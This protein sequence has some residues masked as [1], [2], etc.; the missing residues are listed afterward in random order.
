MQKKSATIVVAVFTI[1]AVDFA[2]NVG[3]LVLI[4]IPTPDIVSL[5]ILDANP[6]FLQFKHVVGVLLSILY[7]S[8]SNSW[9]LHG[10][11]FLNIPLS[12]VYH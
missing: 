4:S 6:S 5:K 9:V 8:L 10:V 3:E 7:Q 2:I 11:C 12:N 1:Y